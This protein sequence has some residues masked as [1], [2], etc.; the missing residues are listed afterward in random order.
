MKKVLL[1]ALL[2]LVMFSGC[3]ASFNIWP[4]NDVSDCE[5]YPQQRTSTFNR[6]AD[7]C[8]NYFANNNVDYSLCNKITNELKKVKCISNIAI[9]LNDID[10]C[11]SINGIF[12]FNGIDIKDTCAHDISINAKEN[13]CEEIK[14]TELKNNCLM[15]VSIEMNDPFLCNGVQGAE[16]QKPGLEGLL[17]KDQCIY[18]V[19]LASNKPEFCVQMTTE[20]SNFNKENCLLKILDNAFKPGS[21]V[22]ES[23]CDLFEIDIYKT[24][25]KALFGN[26]ISQCLDEECFSELAIL[27]ADESLCENGLNTDMIDF[28]YFEYVSNSLKLN[29]LKD[30]SLCDKISEDYS[31]KDSCYTNVATSLNDPKICENIKSVEALENCIKYANK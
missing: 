26:D 17:F 19:A 21:T 4:P 5:N 7:D 27:N 16:T 3:I 24:K 15:R 8:Y 18:D 29:E 6:D 28:C 22:D 10:K 30:A 31:N 11:R 13:Y 9:D 12:I 25:C 2:G 14:N 23:I 1:I 20:R